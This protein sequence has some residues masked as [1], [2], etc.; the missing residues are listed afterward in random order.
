MTYRKSLFPLVLALA[1]LAAAAPP[2]STAASAAVI[3]E[4]CPD[5]SETTTVCIGEQMCKGINYSYPTNGQC[6][7]GESLVTIGSVPDACDAAED[8]TPAP[9]MCTGNCVDQG[10]TTS[11][12]RTSTCCKVTVT[13]NCTLPVQQE[14]L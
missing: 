11:K 9:G 8:V 14:E 4:S 3:K 5:P 2:L 12:V 1:C 13:R 6:P 7:A 10:T